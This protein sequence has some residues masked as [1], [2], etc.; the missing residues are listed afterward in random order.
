MDHN[1]KI[2]VPENVT[3][4][5]KGPITTLFG[6]AARHIGQGLSDKAEYWKLKNRLKIEEKIRRLGE[7]FHRDPDQLRELSYGESFRAVEAASLEEEESV[8]DLW[9]ALLHNAHDASTGVT[10][11]KVFVDLLKSIGGAEALLLDA[12]NQ[13]KKRI[14]TFNAVRNVEWAEYCDIKSKNGSPLTSTQD[15]VPS[16]S[17]TQ[18][19]GELGELFQGGWRQLSTE[20]RDAAIQNLIRLRCIGT[21]QRPLNL[22]SLSRRR[23]I[24]TGGGSIHIEEPDTQAIATNL[25]E[26]ERRINVICGIDDAKVAEPNEGAQSGLFDAIPELSLSFTP[27]GQRLM[28]ASSVSTN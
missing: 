3:D 19:R 24:E 1:I 21:S 17:N 13:S 8:Q 20:I 5:V 26:M 11:E 15:F 7:Q 18:I 12:L 22:N 2:E 10:V 14:L 9:A 16:T 6:D 23:S 4:L 28:N 25:Y 27:L